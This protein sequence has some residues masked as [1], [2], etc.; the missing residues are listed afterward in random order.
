MPI[1]NP[2][3]AQACST[4]IK[5]HK[6]EIVNGCYDVQVSP[7]GWID[8]LT[9]EELFFLFKYCPSSKIALGSSNKVPPNGLSILSKDADDFVRAAVALNQNTLKQDLE[10][11]AMDFVNDVQKNVARNKNASAR[12]FEILAKNTLK[13]QYNDVGYCLIT[14]PRCPDNV[15]L[16]LAKHP[17]AGYQKSLA[18]NR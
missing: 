9:S 15:L 5:Q 4:F 8:E 18:R 16:L 2:P 10:L 13:D 14:N 7:H 11:L 17:D 1:I 12:A 3:D 6:E